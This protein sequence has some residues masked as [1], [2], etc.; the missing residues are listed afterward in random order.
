MVSACAQGQEGRLTV[1]E[2]V[3]AHVVAGRVRVDE[4]ERGNVGRVVGRP[5]VLGRLGALHGDG[6]RDVT[7]QEA[8]G[9]HEVHDAA[10]DLDDEQRHDDAAEQAPAGD[11]DVDLLDVL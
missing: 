3:V 10:A 8:D 5:R 7:E 9:A 11:R 2:G 1:G 6:P 4:E